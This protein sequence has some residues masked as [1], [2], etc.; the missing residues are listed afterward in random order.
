MIT[1]GIA[2]GFAVVYFLLQLY[3]FIYW[4]LTPKISSTNNAVAV[5]GV[6]IVVVAWN[7][8]HVI[9]KCLQGLVDQNYPSAL[10]EIIVIDDHSTDNTVEVIKEM[11]HPQIRVRPEI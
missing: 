10:F 11:N 2:L 7:E 3:Y 6:T 8:A 4:Q 9:R 1:L 5:E